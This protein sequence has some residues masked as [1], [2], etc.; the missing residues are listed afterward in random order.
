MQEM[1]ATKKRLIQA[2]AVN[3][4][5]K[6]FLTTDDIL[7]LP[8]LGKLKSR[9]DAKLRPF[10]Y[11]AP[12][13]TVTGYRLAEVLT[14][15]KN[16][17]GCEQGAVVCRFL[18]QE[19]F[20]ALAQLHKRNNLFHAVS[21]RKEDVAILQNVSYDNKLSVAIDVA[22]GDTESMHELYNLWREQV[23]V[24]DIMSGSVCSPAGV[25]RAAQAG[26]THIRLGVGPGAACT[27]R[28]QTG[29]GNPQLSAVYLAHKALVIKG[30][31]DK[32]TLI[33][34]GGIRYPGDAVKYLAAGADA[35]MLGSRFSTCIESHGWK[36]HK[37]RWWHKPQLVKRFRGQASA[38]FQLDVFGK[39]S[40][41]PEGATG[42]LIEPT[43]SVK[44]LVGEF[45]DG[46]RSAL[47]YLGLTSINELNPDNVTFIRITPSASKEG[48]PHGT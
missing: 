6:E 44:D 20:K 36:R 23:F 2:L 9:K 43:C 21:G 13:D 34:D 37:K 8:S 4:L 17:Q 19:Q 16:H 32:V 10:I 35:I 40:R 33:A 18:P 48:G 3:P 12:M 47:S 46:I 31:R 28:L 45:E 29:C 22:H 39:K 27:T 41:C 1:A 42:P 24:Q 26:C 38:S 25:I 7:L 14:R 11:S 5:D 30:L 15:S